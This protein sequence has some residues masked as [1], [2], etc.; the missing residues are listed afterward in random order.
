MNSYSKDSNNW[1]KPPSILN[2]P[3]IAYGVID[4]SSA[5]DRNSLHDLERAL[6]PKDSSEEYLKN[7]IAGR[8]AAHAALKKLSPPEN[9][10]ILR[11]DDGAP[12]W[13]S[14][15]I[16]SIAH[17]AGSAIAVTAKSTA[18]TALGIDLERRD[19]EVSHAVLERIGNK[20]EV[21]WV[22]SAG[23]EYNLPLFCAREALYK[24]L[25]MNLKNIDLWRKIELLWNPD[26]GAFLV[27]VARGAPS[28]LE[29]M[30]IEI[31][32]I[33]TLLCAVA[34]ARSSSVNR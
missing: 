29:G 34:Y 6:I 31:G 22:S 3:S 1:S 12:L 33:K 30:T 16:G 8:L 13:P 9:S 27:D 11:A 4:S 17:T 24:A 10:P 23:S 5:A 20:A 7:F 25:P 2:D 26:I 19:R 28:S 18:F 14:E 32:S 15:M 21:A